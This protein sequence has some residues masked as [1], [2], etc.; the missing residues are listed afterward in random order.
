MLN[1]KTDTYNGCESAEP[2]KSALLAFQKCRAQGG[3]YECC[4]QLAASGGQL[5]AEL[6]LM[7]NAGSACYAGCAPG[8]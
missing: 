6:A 3:G 5:G 4:T 7:C 2:C 8:A 1:V